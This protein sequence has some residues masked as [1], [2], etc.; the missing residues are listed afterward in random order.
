MDS[1]SIP[2]QV[3]SIQFGTVVLLLANHI[4]LTLLLGDK[5]ALWT[6]H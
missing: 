6:N 2:N 3:T 1:T 5:Q 4:V